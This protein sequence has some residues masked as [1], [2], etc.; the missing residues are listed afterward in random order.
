MIK[1]TLPDLLKFKR[2]QLMLTQDEMAKFI[3]IS[4]ITY[5]NLESGKRKPYP[6]TLRTITEKLKIDPRCIKEIMR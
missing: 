6:H 1:I 5:N 3:G 2:E 4:R